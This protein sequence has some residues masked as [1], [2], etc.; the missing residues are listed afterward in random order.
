DLADVAA[1]RVRVRGRVRQAPH[2]DVECAAVARRGVAAVRAGADGGIAEDVGVGDLILPAGADRLPAGQR[3]EAVD[4]HVV[5]LAV[6]VVPAA[7][8]TMRYTIDS[9]C[10]SA[11]RVAYGGT[12]YW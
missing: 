4:R 12:A 8:P 3:A 7:V 9:G 6:G 2:H 10:M 1:G 5:K 11:R